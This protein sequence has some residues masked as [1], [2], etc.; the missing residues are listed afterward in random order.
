[1]I[2]LQVLIVLSAI[3]LGT[4]L[5][6]ISLGIMGALG[7]ALLVF[8]FNIKPT[9]PP[10]EVLLIITSVI[11]AASALESAGGLSYLTGLSERT[12]R[13]YPHR[14]TFIAPLIMYIFTFLA[15]T[16]HIIYSILP[17]VAT[18]ARE[19]GVRPER[20]LTVTVIAAQQ[21][22]MASPISAPTAILLSILAPYGLELTDLLCVLVP[23]TLGGLLVATLVVNKVGKEL[24]E[25]PIYAATLQKD[26]IGEDKTSTPTGHTKASSP[27]AKRAVALFILGIFA[28]VM[29]GAFKALRPSWQVQGKTVYLGMPVAIEIIMLSTAA[30]MVIF[31]KLKATEITK[32]AVFGAGI[33]AVISILGIAWLGDTFVRANQATIMSSVQEQ[34]LRYPWQ[35]SFI[36][37]GMS[38]LL[39]SQS[40][41]LRALMPLGL[42]L[43]I[44]AVTLLAAAPAVNGLFFIP[45]YP[46]VLAAIHLDTTGTTRIGRFLLNHSF[47]LPGLIATSVAVLIAFGL[48]RYFF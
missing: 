36:L 18:V 22:A 30:L 48:V 19:T 38:I 35:F 1:M 17:I 5:K 46:M 34:I 9:D 26:K 4:K 27:A 40:A 29:L 21:A 32:T 39:V 10:F 25:D 20:P 31:C 3:I 23:A 16:G 2:G 44:P 47:M 7:L 33:Q 12:I 11:T 41:T 6:G 42:A 28:V 14:I 24:H 45:N 15:G 8:G 13:K 43:G 37:F